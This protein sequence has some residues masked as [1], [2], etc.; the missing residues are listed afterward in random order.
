MIRK[1]WG[2]GGWEIEPHPTSYKFWGVMSPF[3]SHPQHLPQVSPSPGELPLANTGVIATQRGPSLT[4]ISALGM[5]RPGH[6]PDENSFS[7]REPEEEKA[8][9]RTTTTFE[10]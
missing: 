7:C 2:E 5:K 6:F 4:W 3:C 10:Y 8:S 1:V 9:K